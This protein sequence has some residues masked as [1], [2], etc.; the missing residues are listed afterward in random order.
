MPQKSTRNTKGLLKTFVLLCGLGLAFAP[1]ARAQDPQPQP[2]P[3]TAPPPLKLIVKEERDQIEA[4]NDAQK[5]LRLIIDFATDHLTRA[6]EQTGHSNY[7]AASAEVG[8]Y[9]AL[10]ENAL[11][12]LS[13]FK[14]DSNMTPD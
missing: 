9:Q 6:E 12:L 8:M 14:R 1:A 7:E 13:T 5:R 3:L 2:T 4:Q 11:Q 10:I